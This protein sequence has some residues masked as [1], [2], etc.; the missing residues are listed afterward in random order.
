MPSTALSVTATWHDSQVSGSLFSETSD[1]LK[2]QAEQPCRSSLPLEPRPPSFKSRAKP[3]RRVARLNASAFYAQ[4]ARPGL[5]VIL[6]GAL[7]RDEPLEERAAPLEACCAAEYARKAA[8]YGNVSRPGCDIYNDW[9]KNGPQLCGREAPH[10]CQ[11]IAARD[12]GGS[13]G[14]ELPPALLAVFDTPPPLPS[15]RDITSQLAMQDGRYSST[16]IFWSRPGDTFGGADHYDI[17]CMGTLSMQYSGTKRWNL[18]APWDVYDAEGRPVR[19]HTRF[20]GKVHAGDVLYYPPGWFQSAA[21]IR[22]IVL[23]TRSPL[24]KC[25]ALPKRSPLSSRPLPLPLPAALGRA[26]TPK[27][28]CGPRRARPPPPPLP[29]PRARRRP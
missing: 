26:A 13:S 15:L 20:V 29:P 17:L 22:T 2:R 24:A 27:A 4:F 6:E 25:R 10:E 28:F 7:S 19:A 9:C 14:A 11:R 1:A 8:R 16:Y 18:W 3:L 21:S 5:P 12:F 23:P